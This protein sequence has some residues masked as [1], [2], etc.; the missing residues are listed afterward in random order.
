MRRI[1]FSLNFLSSGVFNHLHIE[2]VEDEKFQSRFLAL[3]RSFVSG[4][5]LMIPSSRCFVDFQ[6]VRRISITRIMNTLLKS[7]YMTFCFRMFCLDLP[8]I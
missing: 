3:I 2:M 6:H 4:L 8:P 1:T 5:D 7:L